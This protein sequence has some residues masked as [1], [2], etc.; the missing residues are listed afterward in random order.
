MPKMD[1]QY[2]YTLGASLLACAME[3]V[4]L[5]VKANSTPVES[6]S[7]ILGELV[8]KIEEI[9]IMLRVAEELKQ[10]A[11]PRQYLYLVEQVVD[12]ARQVEGWRTS[13]SPKKTAPTQNKTTVKTLF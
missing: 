13:C 6:R 12:C 11:S 9:T 4:R 7:A 2:K 3:A 8:W 1:K 5:I 10:F